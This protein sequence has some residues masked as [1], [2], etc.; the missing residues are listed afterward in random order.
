MV[1]RKEKLLEVLGEER[2]ALCYAVRGFV[3]LSPF[4]TQSGNH[5]QL[6][7]GWERA[8]QAME[9]AFARPLKDCGPGKGP[10]FT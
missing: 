8:E 7:K 1:E 3:K 10:A 5:I 2:W 6:E 4:C 9:C